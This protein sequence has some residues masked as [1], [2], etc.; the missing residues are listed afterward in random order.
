[1][2]FYW[3]LCQ[4]RSTSATLFRQCSIV[5]AIRESHGALLQS[6][7]I[8]LA[9]K[10]YSVLTQL[11]SFWIAKPFKPANLFQTCKTTVLKIIR[12]RLQN[13]NIEK[14]IHMG[15]GKETWKLGKASG[16]VEHTSNCNSRKKDFREWDDTIIWESG[17]SE[18]SRIFQM[19][20]TNP[21][22]QEAQQVSGR[23]HWNS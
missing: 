2:S 9:R 22:I 20:D 10:V 5:S 14:N 1:M 15:N 18:F 12:Y 21:Q 8:T 13:Q 6:W 3:L 17:S 7:M 19:K 4:R 23:R 11:T 16:N